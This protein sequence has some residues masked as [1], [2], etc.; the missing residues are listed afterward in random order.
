MK[1][2]PTPCVMFLKP[3]SLMSKDLFMFVLIYISRG[4]HAV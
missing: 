3:T 4:Y 2:K 1:M